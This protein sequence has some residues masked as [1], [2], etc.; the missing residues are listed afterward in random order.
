MTFTGVSFVFSHRVVECRE[1]EYFPFQRGVM[2]TEPEVS[3]PAV[4]RNYHEVLRNDLAKVLMPLAEAGDLA[5]FAAAWD[6]YCA[7]IAVHAA[8][9]D[10]V[11]GAGGG[12]AAMLDHYF[13]GAAGASVFKEEHVHEQSHQ[14]AVTVAIGEGGAALRTA[15][16]AYRTAAEAHLKHEEDVMVPLI[17]R[18]PNPKAP[19][20]AQWCIPAGIAHGGFE[21]FVAHGVESLATYGSAKN[22]PAV[23]ARVWVHALRAVCSPEQWAIYLRSPAMRHPGPFGRPSSTRCPVS[24]RRP[25][26]ATHDRTR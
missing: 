13:D 25:R 22:P 2:M 21:H 23:A 5:N 17:M 16:D 20:F 26:P 19:K 10:G 3:A 15:F 6:S 4:M 14:H 18:L 7:A 1:L 24:K 11:D 12:S 8:M 9:E